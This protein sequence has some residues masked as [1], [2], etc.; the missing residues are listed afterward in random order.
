MLLKWF[1][2]KVFLYAAAFMFVSVIDQLML[3]KI[4]IFEIPKYKGSRWQ[5]SVV[6]DILMRTDV[7][8]QVNYLIFPILWGATKDLEYELSKIKL[9]NGAT[10]IFYFPCDAEDNTPKMYFESVMHAS[11]QAGIRHIF[12][13]SAPLRK[14]IGRIN[15]IS[16]PYPCPLAQVIEP[17]LVKDITVSF[18]G[19]L[20]HRIRSHIRQLD[21]LDGFFIQTYSGYFEFLPIAQ[22]QKYKALYKDILGRSRFSL[23]PRGYEP[24]S[25]RFWE[26]LHA[27]AIPILIAD[28]YRLPEIFDWNTCVIRVSEKDFAKRPEIIVDIINSISPEKELAMRQACYEASKA[29]SGDNLVSAII[30]YFDKQS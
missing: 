30:K 15:I 20:T 19:G 17:A 29:S 25:I 8:R 22:Q 16:I 12:T 7:E 18:L 27:G 4:T 10:T 3:C 26:S 13:L 14:E 9:E 21:V 1:E 28:N 6:T 2:N 5:E 11:K 24:G 23:C